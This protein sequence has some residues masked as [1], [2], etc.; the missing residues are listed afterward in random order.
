MKALHVAYKDIQILL[1]DRGA[2]I[3]MFLLPF[4]FIIVLSTALQGIMSGD[5]DRL[6]DLPVVNLDNGGRAATTLLANL[7]EAG[8][9][10]VVSY[11]HAEAEAQLEEFKIAHVLTIP[12]GFSDDV[13]NGRPITLVLVS[14]PEANETD[15]DSVLRTINGVA[16][17]LALQNQL[18]TSFQQMGSMLG[19]APQDFQVFTTERVVA[20][21][22]SQFQR[23]QTDPLVVVEQTRPKS[24][25]ERVEEPNSVQQFVPGLVI[26]FVF[27]SAQSTA[28]S[29]YREKQTGSF[30]RLIVAPISKTGMMIG[31]MIPNFVTGLIQIVVIFAISILVLPLIGLDKLTLGDDPLALALIALALVLCSTSMG[32]LI[33]AIARTEGQI[34]GVS[35]LVLWTMAAIGG[36]LYPTY[37]QG[38]VLNTIGKAVP[39]Y[40]AVIASQDLIVRGRGLSDVLLEIAILMGFA[41]LFFVIGVWRFDFD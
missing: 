5:D 37:L 6:I 36:C 11:Q 24:L 39:H 7:N 1:K 25:S 23:A 27:L 20:Q 16:Q 18:I 8:G 41:L 9:L 4:V 28:F 32:I 12:V 21:A 3:N 29:I 38:G 34:T 14:H 31:K 13:P 15:T 26:L 17:G 35:G 40:W 22:E 33:A 2:L 30:R 10:Q 19:T